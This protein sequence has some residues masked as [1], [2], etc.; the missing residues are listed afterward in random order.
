MAL[1]RTSLA[2]IRR[3]VR[4]QE[5]DWELDEE[6]DGFV[7]M[8]VEEKMKQ[9]VDPVSAARAVSSLI[10]SESSEVLYDLQPVA[11]LSFAKISS[12][13]KMA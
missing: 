9:S 10:R 3:L 11:T 8:A 5:I 1:L 12:A 4:K 2:G 13:S 7:E 6:L